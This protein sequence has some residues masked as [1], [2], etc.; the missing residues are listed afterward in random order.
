M[1]EVKVPFD[2]VAYSQHAPVVYL[3]SS[4]I[5]WFRVNIQYD[6]LG[7]AYQNRLNEWHAEGHINGL[8]D[9][10]DQIIFKFPFKE[11]AILFKLVWC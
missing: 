6:K 7:V 8:T 5:R 1:Y 10:N 11:D 2:N 9:N 4:L 3:R